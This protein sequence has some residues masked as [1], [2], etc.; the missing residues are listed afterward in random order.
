MSGSDTSDTLIVTKTIF[1][2][3]AQDTLGVRVSV[4]ILFVFVYL[5]WN[6]HEI[7]YKSSYIV[8]KS[9]VNSSF[10]PRQLK[11]MF[12]IVPDHL[13]LNNKRNWLEE[14]NI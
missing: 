14:S 3:W 10:L 4:A 8:L 13:S 7:E 2:L 5:I 9:V 11:S 1:G 6:F 12:N